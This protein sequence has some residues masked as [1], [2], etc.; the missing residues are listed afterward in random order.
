[1]FYVGYKYVQRRRIYRSLRIARIAPLDLRNRMDAGE[2]LTIV[3]LR[4]PIEWQEGWIPGSLKLV[5]DELDSM[6][7]TIEPGEVVLY[8]SCPNEAGSARAALRLKRRGVRSVRPLDGGFTRWQEL[9]FPI[10]VPLVQPA[11]AGEG[12][13]EP[14]PTCRTVP[15]VPTV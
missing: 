11:A 14:A 8:C 12:D 1:V 15:K 10:E 6:I 2:K 7:P 3:D 9:G 5:S 13:P 4:N